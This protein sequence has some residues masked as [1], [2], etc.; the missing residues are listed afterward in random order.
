M[1]LVPSLGF[2]PE[3]LDA[4][5][6]GVV[7]SI[8]QAHRQLQ[9]G[10][11]LVNRGGLQDSSVNR[12][13]TSY[14]RNPEAERK[15]FSRNT[16]EDMVVLRLQSDSGRELGMLSWF[17]VHPTSINN[18]NDLVNGDNKGVASYLFEQWKNPN[19]LPGEGSFVGE[20]SFC[21]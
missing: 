8:A 2:W 11:V 9:S 6:E 15:Q 4:I 19:S 17:A 16:D 14:D 7:R 10:S 13:P 21:L 12:S 3:S 20:S 5:V 18:T 1:Y